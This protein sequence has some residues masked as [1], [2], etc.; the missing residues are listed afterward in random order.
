MA[1]DLALQ[2]LEMTA[3]A[4]EF[5]AALAKAAELKAAAAAPA[6]VD[7]SALAEWPRAVAQA[8]QA[9]R[10][11]MDRLDRTKRLAEQFGTERNAGGGYW[12]LSIE[13]IA[14]MLDAHA[15]AVIARH[16]AGAAA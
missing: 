3:V 13:R 16:V 1:R 7:L 11:G 2:R 8:I 15:A 5:D 12:V 4:G 6:P 10:A 9:E 14:D